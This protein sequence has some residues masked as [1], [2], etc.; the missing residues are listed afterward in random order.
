M[1]CKYCGHEMQSQGNNRIEGEY[2]EI[3]VCMNVECKS[4]YELFRNSKGTILNN[5]NKWFNPKEAK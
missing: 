5:K 3:F 1:N 2:I 4:V